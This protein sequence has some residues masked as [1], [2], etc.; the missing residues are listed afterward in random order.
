[1]DINPL[2]VFG[3]RRLDHC[4]PHFEKVF[5]NLKT[6][7]KVISDWVYINLSG[8]FY[9]GDHYSHSLR[10]GDR[11]QIEKCIAFEIPAEASYF[12]LLLSDIN[13]R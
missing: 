8:R 7:E 1:M 3:L 6:Y 10:E 9:L 2:N 11:V 12:S 4:P 5:F 13:Q